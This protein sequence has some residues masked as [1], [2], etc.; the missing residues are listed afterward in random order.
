MLSSYRFLL[1]TTWSQ[2]SAASLKLCSS[3]TEASIPAPQVTLSRKCRR[4]IAGLVE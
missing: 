4:H 2:M 3:R 1:S